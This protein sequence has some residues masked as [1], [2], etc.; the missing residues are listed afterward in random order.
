MAV[1]YIV[2]CVRPHMSRRSTRHTVKPVGTLSHKYVPHSDATRFHT[3][4]ETTGSAKVL[5]HN[6]T[7]PRA[8]GSPH[9]SALAQILSP[10]GSRSVYIGIL[11][12]PRK[13]RY[14][15]EI[16]DGNARTVGAGENESMGKRDQS[17]CRYR[18]SRCAVM[19]SNLLLVSSQYEAI[20][21]SWYNS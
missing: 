20:L 10:E 19:Q 21:V 4:T 5:S 6:P 12:L 7:S 3:C 11:C 9:E 2:H 13:S 8:R 15:T 18:G 16:I 17:R 14:M 1:Q